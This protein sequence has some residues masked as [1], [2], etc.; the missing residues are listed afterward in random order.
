MDG[1]CGIGRVGDVGM[2]VLCVRCASWYDE[3]RQVECCPHGVLYDDVGWCDRV[4]VMKVD[5]LT[6][7]TEQCERQF[8]G[9]S[10][11]VFEKDVG[12]YRFVY[13]LVGEAHGVRTFESIDPYADRDMILA[14]ATRCAEMI[15]ARIWRVRGRM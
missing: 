12:R 2:W 8:P 3:N 4:G 15:V 1:A 10:W 5:I 11:E 6:A 13:K 9:V 7:M 14:N